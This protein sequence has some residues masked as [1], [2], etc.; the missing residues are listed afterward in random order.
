VKIYPAPE[1]KKQVKQFL[2]LASYYR[3]FIPHLSEIA[4][5]INYLT[6]KDVPFT[7]TNECQ[8]AFEQIKQKL[9]STPILAFPDF[10]KQFQITIDASNIGI[11]AILS[12]IINGYEKVIAYASRNL[13]ASE[14]NYSSIKKEL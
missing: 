7:W 2:G 10:T 4:Y 12:Q 11:G 9:M 13:S 1:N 3:K 14:K 8:E 6:K 5:P